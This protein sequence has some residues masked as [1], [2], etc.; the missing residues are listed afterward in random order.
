MKTILVANQ[1]GGSGKTLLADTLATAFEL[2]EVKI[3]FVDLDQQGGA[4]HSTTDNEDAAVQIVDTPGALQKD[5]KNWMQ[6]ADFI[7]IPTMMSSR[8]IPPLIKTLEVYESIK[9]KVPALVVFNRWNRTNNTKNFIEW[10][11]EDYP[12]IDTAILCDSTAFNDAGAKGLSIEEYRPR[13]NGAKQIREIYSVIKHE[14][15]IKEGFR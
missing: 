12:N 2:D 3:N 11:E 13:S 9:T 15:N 5:L 4:I 6:D 7:V 14:L 8:D 1:K 10:F